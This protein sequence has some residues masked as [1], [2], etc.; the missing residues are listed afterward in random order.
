[1]RGRAV[2]KLDVRD[3]CCWKVACFQIAPSAASVGQDPPFD[4][5]LPASW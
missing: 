5:F 4:S 1:L 3:P 2:G